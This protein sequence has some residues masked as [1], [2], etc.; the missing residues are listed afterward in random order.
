[1]TAMQDYTNEQRPAT[2]AVKYRH[3]TA[4]TAFGVLFLAGMGVVFC[5]P[6]ASYLHAHA[7]AM[8]PLRVLTLAMPGLFGVIG[9]FLVTFALL[10]A[11]ELFGRP[12]LGA[13]CVWVDKVGLWKGRE[14]RPRLLFRWDEMEGV[15][16]RRWASNTPGRWVF[17]AAGRQHT[18]WGHWF[19]KTG[20]SAFEHTVSQVAGR[21]VGVFAEKGSAP[22]P[23]RPQQ[24][25]PRIAFV[26]AHANLTCGLLFVAA[27][28]AIWMAAAVI[29][30]SA[31]VAAV[32]LVPGAL[33]AYV[34][35]EHWLWRR[36]GP[37]I[38]V[39]D[40]EGLWEGRRDDLALKVRWADLALWR[41]EGGENAAWTFE[42][43]G[44]KFALSEGSINS[45]EKDDFERALERASGKRR[46]K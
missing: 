16:R 20:G 37:S 46:A 32:G 39:V 27:F 13:T 40:S 43:T 31:L 10:L 22:V 7:G 35:R 26:P 34:A 23:Y 41:F 12:F 44:A 8:T 42:T 14:A 6:L 9:L 17:S 25:V 36:R 45:R 2:D 4:Q 38:V 21:P 1:M 11:K 3:S 19:D 33:L 30:R 24:A 28:T 29:N 5:Y 18:V 15:E